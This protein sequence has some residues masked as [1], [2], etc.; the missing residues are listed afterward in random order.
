MFNI[1]IAFIGTH[2]CGKTTLV[3][4][5][6]TELKKR[7][8]H[9]GQLEEIARSCP[10]PINEQTTKDAQ[11][12]ILVTTISKE[13][14]LLKRYDHLVCDRSVL[15]NYAYFY[16]KFGHDKTL[17]DL[18]KSWVQTYDFLFKVPINKEYLRPDD[19]RTTDFTF[20]NDIDKKVDTL[21]EETCTKFHYFKNIK[22]CVNLITKK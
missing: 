16:H 21:L 14:E 12:W 10:L 4:E 9:V 17:F 8:F 15:D 5:L 6:C 1:K 3:Y 19:T 18:V 13:I 7:N 2:S 11:T 20:Q 22:D